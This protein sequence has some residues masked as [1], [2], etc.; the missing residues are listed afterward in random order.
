MII[1]KYNGVW[2]IHNDILYWEENIRSLRLCPESLHL[3]TTQAA[4]TG[5]GDYCV[6]MPPS[7]QEP[8]L[9]LLSA[10]QRVTLN[11]DYAMLQLLLKTV[12][13]AIAPRIVGMLSETISDALSEATTVVHNLLGSTTEPEKLTVRSNTPKKSDTTKL[14]QYMY[15]FIIYAHTDW[16]N[17]NRQNP[18]NKKTM[19]ELIEAINTYM[20]TDK[21]RTTLSRIWN[22]RIDRDNLPVGTAYFDCP[23]KSKDLS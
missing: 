6:V 23:Y 2:G 16:K 22:G 7:D 5:F 12:V 15:D 4:E 20:G 17:F 18:K 1:Q 9:L 3:A 19:E 13:L 14:T 11:E 10:Y 8:T 21:S